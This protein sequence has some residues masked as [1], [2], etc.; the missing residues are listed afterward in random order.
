MYLW[1]LYKYH[2]IF[3]LR[4]LQ[5]SRYTQIHPQPPPPPC[6]FFGKHNQSDLSATIDTN[7]RK[8]TIITR[9]HSCLRFDKMPSSRRS[10]RG[11]REYARWLSG[12]LVRSVMMIM[13]PFLYYYLNKSEGSIERWEH[14][15]FCSIFSANHI[16]PERYSIV[17]M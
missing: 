6:R 2:S 16:P 13:W 17:M 14:T 12:R 9:S 8:E 1:L 5:V 7:K 15:C 3:A 10:G 11:R 4:V